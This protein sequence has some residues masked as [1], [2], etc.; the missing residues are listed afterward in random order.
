MYNLLSKSANGLMRNDTLTLDTRMKAIQTEQRL[1]RS[2]L[3]DIK[4]MINKLLIDKQLQ[5]QVDT[6][7]E[8]TPPPD[9][10]DLD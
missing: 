4:L 5:H 10:A 9:P 6:Y 1:Q 3:K 7:F 2:D 8:N